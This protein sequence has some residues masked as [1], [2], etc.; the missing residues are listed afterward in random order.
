MEELYECTKCGESLPPSGFR[1]H[2]NWGPRG[3]DTVCRTCQAAH[4]RVRRAIR[5]A[6]KRPRIEELF[7]DAKA[8]FVAAAKAVNKAKQDQV[9]CASAWREAGWPSE[10]PEL[11]AVRNAEEDVI[12]AEAVYRRR[13]QDVNAVGEK[14][15]SELR[16]MSIA[17]REAAKSKGHRGP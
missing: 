15:A 12:K 7:V 9:A 5:R 17:A 1:K 14:L 16:A 6:E 2:A 4:D 13:A 11:D 10:G 3:L 8:R